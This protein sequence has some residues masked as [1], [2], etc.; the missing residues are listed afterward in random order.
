MT[1]GQLLSKLIELEA[2]NQTNDVLIELANGDSVHI[3]D[4]SEYNDRVV[5]EV[6]D[7]V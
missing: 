3:A 2:D 5:L 1:L 7:E 4:V 6:G